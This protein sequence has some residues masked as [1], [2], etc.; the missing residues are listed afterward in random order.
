MGG[1]TRNSW[2]FV[3][4]VEER[5]FARTLCSATITAGVDKAWEWFAE[6]SKQA[7][8]VSTTICIYSGAGMN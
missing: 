5:V 1:F 7:T 8:W 4:G 6:E 2:N 3:S